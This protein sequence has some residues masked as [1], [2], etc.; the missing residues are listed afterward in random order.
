MASRAWTQGRELSNEAFA[1]VKA[2]R[3]LLG[4]PIRAGVA[5]IVVVVVLGGPAAVIA[6]SSD[7]DVAAGIALAL[8]IVAA[9]VSAVVV[10]RFQGGLVAAA[11]KAL[12]GEESSYEQGMRDSAGHTGTL[13]SW[14][15]INGTVGVVLGTLQSGGGQSGIIGIVLRIVGALVSVAWAAITFFVVPVIIFESLGAVPSIKRSASILKERWGPAVSGVVRIGL[16]LIVLLYLPGFLLIFAGGWIAISGDD[17]AS[18]TLGAL[19]FGAGLLLCIVGGIVN[20]TV[21]SVFGVALYR[22]ATT[23]QALGPF[24]E[25]QLVGSMLQKGEKR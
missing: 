22:F 25:D 15:L 1:V 13:A 19:L 11:D 12:R 3:Y 23:G 20:S 24:T 8:L 18:I 10:A 21:R 2:N 6:A 14:G 4:Y 17:P 7:S 5:S 9:L 16:R